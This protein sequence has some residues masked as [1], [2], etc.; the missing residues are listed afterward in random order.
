MS[1]QDIP[2]YADGWPVGEDDSLAEALRVAV[3]GGEEVMRLLVA[4]PFGD[5]PEHERDDWRAGAKVARALAA[6]AEAACRKLAERNGQAVK[7][8]VPDGDIYVTRSVT[9]W[10]VAAAGLWLGHVSK[11]LGPNGWCI[12]DLDSATAPTF[13]AADAAFDAL[14]AAVSK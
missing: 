14:R 5:L 11:M 9:G 6:G 2:R 7:Y 4:P 13:P 8:Y 1:D 10:E 12:V 3:T